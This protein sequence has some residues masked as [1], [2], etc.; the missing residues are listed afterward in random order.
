LI[1]YLPPA[2]H[3]TPPVDDPFARAQLATVRV[4]LRVLWHRLEAL[5]HELQLMRVTTGVGGE[6]AALL[7]RL[8]CEWTGLE[9]VTGILGELVHSARSR[10]TT[11]NEAN[12]HRQAAGDTTLLRYQAMG[13]RFVVWILVA[14]HHNIYQ[15][16]SMSA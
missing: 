3:G 6:A 11:S 8:F 15:Q 10:S 5:K 16:L 9:L 12:H 13:R 1:L 7:A 14:F 2:A 4:H